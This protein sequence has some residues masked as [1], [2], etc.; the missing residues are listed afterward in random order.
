MESLERRLVQEAERLERARGDIV[1]EARSA[2]REA[3]GELGRSVSMGAAA[4]RLAHAEANGEREDAAGAAV[5]PVQEATQRAPAENATGEANSLTGLSKIAAQLAE[6]ADVA[7]RAAARDVL[8]GFSDV[9]NQMNRMQQELQEILLAMNLQKRDAE[10]CASERLNQARRL[11]LIQEEQSTEYAH[12][13]HCVH[14]LSSNAITELSEH[15]SAVAEKSDSLE[16]ELAQLHGKVVTEFAHFKLC[17]SEQQ[18]AAATASEIADTVRN[19]VDQVELSMYEVAAKAT[20]ALQDE[21]HEELECCVSRT[22]MGWN[23][24]EEVSLEANAADR[25][26]REVQAALHAANAELASV[27]ASIDARHHESHLSVCSVQSS[28]EGRVGALA[29]CLESAVEAC[30]ASAARDAALL[31]EDCRAIATASR[32]EAEHLV[33]ELT[34]TRREAAAAMAQSRDHTKSLTSVSANYG[35]LAAE[36]THLQQQGLSHEWCV[37]KCM[38]RLEYLCIA[39]D[40]GVWLDSPEFSLGC[41]GSVSLRLY[42]RGATDEDTQCAVGLSTVSK[43]GI[44]LRAA[45]LRLSLSVSGFN[46]YATLYVKDDGCNLWLAKGFGAVEALVGTNGHVVV[47]V[48]IPVGPWVSLDGDAFGGSRCSEAEA[49]HRRRPAGSSRSD[50]VSWFE[51]GDDRPVAPPSRTSSRPGSASGIRATP[52]SPCLSSRPTALAASVSRAC[53]GVSSGGT[54][55][56]PRWA[57]IMVERRKECET[58]LDEVAADVGESGAA[59]SMSLSAN[60]VPT[61]SPTLGRRSMRTSGGDTGVAGRTCPNPPERS[62]P[63]AAAVVSA[64]T[65]G[66]AGASPAA[67]PSAIAGA[68]AI[69]SSLQRRGTVG[70]GSGSAPGSLSSSGG[71]GASAA[72]D[73]ASG[74]GAIVSAGV[75]TNPFDK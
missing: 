29:D 18:S 8:V 61:A 9:P 25:I 58:P 64:A 53:G 71:A 32:S 41:L 69:P 1:A 62:N 16:S 26:S 6:G 21:L 36:L 74:G 51:R 20:A 43:A 23:F 55:L 10:V 4:R 24:A 63:F 22:N 31:S 33:S 49:R 59:Q 30:E 7:A 72:A 60:V 68:E 45:P 11:E 17:N 39:G 2:V 67:A 37:E 57:P 75:S 35:R 34:E 54:P 27:S 46:R 19:A 70:I 42:P 47:G 48:E 52:A 50:D 65:R 12:L 38:Q 66:C 3:L 44:G 14:E 56:S 73:G 15:S 28:L 5:A 40:T 13:K